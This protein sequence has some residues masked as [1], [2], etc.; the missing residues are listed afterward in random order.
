VLEK[1]VNMRTIAFILIWLLASGGQKPELGSSTNP[2]VEAHIREL[3]ET[4][5]PDSFLRGQ[6]QAG[7]RGEGIH[8]A[9]M[10]GMR[11][12]A[13]K[14]TV[15]QIHIRFM[16]NGKPKDMKIVRMLYYGAYD[17][18]F[19]QITDQ[20][21]LEKIRVSGLEQQLEKAALERAAQG[22][23]VDIPRPKPVPFVGGTSVDLLDDEWLPI[24]HPL[25]GAV[26]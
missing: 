18:S 8:Y 16:G 17:S 6:L 26:K 10:D 22:S 23:W 12:E 20:T 25:F 24:T 11:R 19:A 13:V 21:S 2:A 3:I 9:W 5:P 15:A 14:K 7:A 1:I 4:L